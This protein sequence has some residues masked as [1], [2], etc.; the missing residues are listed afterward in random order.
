MLIKLLKKAPPLVRIDL[1]NYGPCE[2]EDIA[3]IP[4]KNAKILLAEKIA[5]EIELY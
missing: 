5:E 2:K 4:Y 1:I 3:N